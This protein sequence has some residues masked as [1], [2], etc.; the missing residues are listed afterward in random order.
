MHCVDRTELLD[1]VHQVRREATALLAATGSPDEDLR[2]L[3]RMVVLL[4]YMTEHL[5]MV[6]AGP[7]IARP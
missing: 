7:A 2:R 1:T 4:S 3:R 5:E 6:E